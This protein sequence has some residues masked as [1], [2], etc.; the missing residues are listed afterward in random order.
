MKI[1]VLGYIVRGPLG[2]LVWHHFQ[3]VYGLHQ[4][5]YEVLFVEDSEEYAA[6]YNPEICRMTTNPTYG[7]NF[8]KKIFSKFNLQNTRTR[9]HKYL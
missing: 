2:G 9:Q 4:M 7:L 8:I 1:A 5:G 6:C 3:Y